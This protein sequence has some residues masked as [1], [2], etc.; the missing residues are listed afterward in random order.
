MNQQ[1]MLAKLQDIHAV[2]RVDTE[3]PAQVLL[4]KPI[5]LLD[6]R[7]RYFPFHLELID[8]VEVPTISSRS[9]P[10]IYDGPDIDIAGLHRSLESPL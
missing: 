5:I 8:S 4:S 3:I 1:Q 10:N 9:K 6:A 7:G 2:V